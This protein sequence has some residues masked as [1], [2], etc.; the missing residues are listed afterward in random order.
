MMD[1]QKEEIAKL[2][3]SNINH[4]VKLLAQEFRQK[5]DNSLAKKKEQL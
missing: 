4:G 3:G 2:L 1:A 5:M